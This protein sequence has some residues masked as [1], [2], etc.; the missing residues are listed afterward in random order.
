ME[1]SMPSFGRYF[2]WPACMLSSC[3]SSVPSNPSPFLR[4]VFSHQVTEGGERNTS[5]LLKLLQITHTMNTAMLYYDFNFSKITQYSGFMNCRIR[6]IAALC[7]SSRVLC[8]CQDFSLLGYV[9]CLVSEWSDV[10][11]DVNNLIT[12]TPTLWV[13]IWVMYNCRCL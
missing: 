13:Q 1:R 6:H 8:V 11:F 7:V 12:N 9:K 5:N 10:L 2:S 4:K 3:S